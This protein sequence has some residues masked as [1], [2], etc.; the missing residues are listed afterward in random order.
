LLPQVVSRLFPDTATREQ[1]TRILSSYGR[2]G[3]HLEVERVH[4]GILKLSGA[5]L[6]AIERWTQLACDDFRDLLIEA[7]YRLS[8]GKDRLRETNPHKYKAL[9]KTEREQ[10]DAWIAT[11]L[12]A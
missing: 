11:V 4:L 9:K 10:Y 12:A 2:D 3:F 8:F 7:E 5:D 6:S 1:A